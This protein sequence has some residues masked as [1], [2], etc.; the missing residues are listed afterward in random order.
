MDERE[1]RWKWEDCICKLKIKIQWAKSRW[2]M[3]ISIEV[4]AENR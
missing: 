2:Q 1:E 4:P 3:N